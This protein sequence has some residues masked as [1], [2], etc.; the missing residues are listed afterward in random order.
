MV[1]AAG[2]E[3]R[4]GVA[5]VLRDLEAEHAVIEGQGAVEVGYAQMH[6]TH[7]RLGMD[8]RVRGFAH[9]VGRPPLGGGSLALASSATF[10]SPFTFFQKVM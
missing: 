1:V 3:E 4:S 8:G 2:G 7:A 10:H 9:G 6:V 5:E